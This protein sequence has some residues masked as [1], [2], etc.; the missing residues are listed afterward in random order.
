MTTMTPTWLVLAKVAQWGG[1]DP[2]PYRDAHG[3]GDG[4][5]DTT[6]AAAVRAAMEGGR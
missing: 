3:V 2:P 4:W 5:A 1:E 6:H